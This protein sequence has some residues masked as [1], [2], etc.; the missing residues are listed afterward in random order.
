MALDFIRYF[1]VTNDSPIGKA[2]QSYLVSLLRIAPVRL[3]SRSG[4]FLE[5]S[6]RRF[7]GLI[8]TPMQG[9]CVSC[10]CTSPASWIEELAVPMPKVN[11]TMDA[12]AS[13]VMPTGPEILGVARGMAE[14]YTPP[15]PN[16]SVLRNVL[17]LVDPPTTDLQHRTASRYE[18]VIAPS[19]TPGAEIARLWPDRRFQGTVV[20]IP[21]TPTGHQSIREAVLGLEAVPTETP[22]R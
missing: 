17:F 6:W 19:L 1:A 18:A 2:A 13:P 15:A 14:L 21:I 7:E 10:V 12:V 3:L 8:M 16:G 11:A 9:K 22:Y 4:G 20:P 5:G